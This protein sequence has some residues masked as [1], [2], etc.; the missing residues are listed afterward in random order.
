[1]SDFSLLRRD[2]VRGH[3]TADGKGTCRDRVRFDHGM[4][5]IKAKP[6]AGKFFSNGLQR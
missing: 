3:A 5:V 6:V 4:A 1:L 2:R